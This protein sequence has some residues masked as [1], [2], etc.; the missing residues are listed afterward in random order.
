ML[1]MRGCVR[2]F[3]AWLG[4]VNEMRAARQ[5]AMAHFTG[6]LAF[7]A[8]NAWRTFQVEQRERHQSFALRMRRS[9]EWSLTLTLTLILTLTLTLTLTLALTL[10][11]TL[12]LTSP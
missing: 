12:T 7:F 4:L 6:N 11:L 10:T 1:T 9:G 5:R 3:V 8:F 2:C